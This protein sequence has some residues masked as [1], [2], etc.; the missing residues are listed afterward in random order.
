MSNLIVLSF[1]NSAEAG[2]ARRALRRL[3][4]E[5]L[6][7]LED[8][9]VVGRTLDGTLHVDNEVSRSVKIGAFGGAFVGA[10]LGFMFPLAGIVAG[11]AVGALGARWLDRGVDPGFVKDVSAALQPGTSALFLVVNAANRDATLAALRAFPGRVYHTTLDSEAEAALRDAL[12]NQPAP[13]AAATAPADGG[14]P[15]RA[16]PPIG[17][18][19]DHVLGVIDRPEEADG[20]AQALRDAGI[21]AEDVHVIH[22]QE[23][24][25]LEEN[26]KQRHPLLH[27]MQIWFLSS[28]MGDPA[29][30]Y[31]RA[32]RRGGTILAVRIRDGGQVER[33][34][35]VLAQHHAHLVRHFTAVT[36]TVLAP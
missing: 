17:F 13:P 33:V 1:E 15:D 8:A 12:G 32:A 36:T 28:D 21:A 10:I 22:G 18:P 23:A 29:T 27:A 24:Q 19:R 9:A 6:L 31:L 34:G 5:G 35:Q 26:L 25:L 2:D 14:P 11:A 3:E 4:H 30:D 7:D 16:E 20:A